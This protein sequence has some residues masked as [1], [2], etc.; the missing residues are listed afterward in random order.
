MRPAL[1]LHVIIPLLIN[2]ALGALAF[3]FSGSSFTRNVAACWFI[4]IVSTAVAF[5]A[6]SGFFFHDLGSRTALLAI[7]GHAIA[8]ILIFA[9]IYRGFGL[10]DHIVGADGPLLDGALAAYFSLVTWTTLGYGDFQP[11]ES[12]RLLAGL[13]AFLGYLF[14]ESGP[15]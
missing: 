7:I 10:Q 6:L 8:L 4:A 9:G 5:S 12:L 3:Y 15:E 1:V 2:V 13:E 14:L 11:A